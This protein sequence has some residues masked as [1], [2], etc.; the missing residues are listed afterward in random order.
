MVWFTLSSRH[1]DGLR[2][3]E[4]EQGMDGIFSP[5][6]DVI[7]EAEERAQREWDREHEPCRHEVLER[8][9]CD[10]Y[11][12]CGNCGATVVE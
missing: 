9:M 1:R 11:P 10:L 6:E 5:I 4:T 12:R 8:R 7:R 2:R 3:N